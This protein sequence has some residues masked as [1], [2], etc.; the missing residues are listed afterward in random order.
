MKKRLLLLS[1][2]VFLILGFLFFAPA[3]THAFSF[4]DIVDG[5]KNFFTPKPPKELTI[6]SQIELAPEGDI[7]NNGRIDAG[8]IIRFSY[9]I[10]NTTDN[11]HTFA[12]LKTNINTKEINSIKNVQGVMSLA[13]KD[14][15]ILIPNLTIKPNQ[16]R[17]ISFEA[18]INFYKDTDQLLSTEPELLNNKK[19]SILKAK[20]EEIT[21]KK[22]SIDSFNKLVHITK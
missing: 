10:V 11:T 14:N 2:V 8:D 15:T 21:V 16:V 18:R 5:V 13:E 4:G 1:S 19:D 17:K 22:M 9:T 3:K 12:T 20:K 7:N 6:D